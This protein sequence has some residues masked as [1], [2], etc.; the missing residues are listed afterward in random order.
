[1][2][3]NKGNACGCGCGCEE[4]H[5][6]LETLTLEFEEGEKVECVVE[7]VFDFDGRE[8]MALTNPEKEEVYIYRYK[9]VN[10]EEFDLED[11]ESDEEFDA[12]AK[13]LES[14][15]TE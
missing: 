12:A 7:G 1:M 10:E 2:T 14:L 8:Y 5:E 13:E 3:E 15:L 9:E 4:E 6:E 11:I